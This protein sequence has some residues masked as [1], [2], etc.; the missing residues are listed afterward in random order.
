[1][2]T[3]REPPPDDIEKS[4]DVL[5]ELRNKESHGPGPVH[6]PGSGGF[7]NRGFFSGLSVGD[8]LADG[9]WPKLGPRQ[10]ARRLRSRLSMA[11]IVR[12]RKP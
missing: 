9:G 8:T 7:L 10:E 2:A 1:M 5:A 11:P 12:E 6:L 3:D 4:L